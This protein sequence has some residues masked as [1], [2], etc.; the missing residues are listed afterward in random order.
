MLAGVEADLT[1]VQE[2]LVEEAE[3]EQAEQTTLL[4]ETLQQTLVRVE[5]VAET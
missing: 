4:A 3:Q 1:K 5:G 2:T